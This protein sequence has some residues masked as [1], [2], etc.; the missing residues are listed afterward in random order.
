MKR[1]N[2]LAYH[3]PRP[4]SSIRIFTDFQCQ[5]ESAD[6]LLLSINKIKRHGN[7]LV[8]SDYSRAKNV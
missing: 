5:I 3:K 2:G 6:I 8:C 4:L 7:Q 1:K